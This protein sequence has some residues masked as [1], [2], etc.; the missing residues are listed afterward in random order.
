MN[1]AEILRQST[2]FGRMLVACHSERSEESSF[3]PFSARAGRDSSLR[4]LE[5]HV[6]PAKLV[7]AKAGSGNPARSG[8][9]D[10]RLGGGDE[11]FTFIPVGWPEAHGRSE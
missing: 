10:P 11:G 7:P 9:V 4:S 8:D 5:S 3:G 2:T 1:D 6:I